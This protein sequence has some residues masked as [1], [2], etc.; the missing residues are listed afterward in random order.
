MIKARTFHFKR[1]FQFG[2]YSLLLPKDI[3]RSRDIER[4]FLPD[5]IK[6]NDSV[7]VVIAEI[8]DLSKFWLYLRESSLDRLMDEMQEFY[9]ENHKRYEIPEMLMVE[10]GTYC[11]HKFL[12]E[13]H[14]AIVVGIIDSATLRVR[15]WNCF[16]KALLGGASGHF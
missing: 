2:D 11:V 6:V 13:F 12:N 3:F 16:L 7:D 9:N 14:R 15:S 5:D 1:L 10:A 4:V 8:Y